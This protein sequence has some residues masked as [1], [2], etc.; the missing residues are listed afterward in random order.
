MET[1]FE[2]KRDLF[3]HVAVARPIAGTLSYSIPA[4]LIDQL[5]V[6]HV[7]LVPL[8][9]RGAET[10]YVVGKTNTVD[11]DVAKVKP[12]HRLIDDQKVF[13]AEQLAFFQ[14]IARYYLVPLGMVIQTAIPSQIRARVL[15]VLRA[16]EA[17]IEALTRQEV[18][19]SNAPILREIISRPDL[20]QKGLTRRLGHD[21]DAAEVKRGVAALIRR[22]W[23]E[24]GEREIGETKGA[25]STVRLKC[26]LNEAMTRVPRA[27]KRMRAI[28]DSLDSAGGAL[29]LPNIIRSHGSS[30]RQSLKRLDAEELLEWGTREK[31][32]AL[33]E[34]PALGPT[35]ALKLNADQQAALDALTRPAVTGCHL[36]YGVTGSGK[37]E[38]FLDAAE[39]TLTQ[40][41]QVL[42]LVPEI[43]LTPQ[44]VGRFRA[45]FGDKVAV[46]HSGLTGGERLGEWRKIRAN[47]AQIA[48]GARS[49]LFAPFSDLGLIVVDEEHDDSYK[50]DDGVPYNAR[51]LAVVLGKLRSCPVVLASA[52]PSMESWYNAQKEH[53]K[54]LHLP[55]RATPRNVP[56]VQLVDLT[57][58]PLEEG[59][60]RPI[61]A[62]EAIDA[63]QE[64]FDAGGKAIVL[65][66]RRGYATLIQCTSCGGTYE[67]PNCGISMT[68]HQRSSRMCCHYC[69]LSLSYTGECPVCRS[70]SLEELGKGTERVVEELEKLFPQI[71]I[72]RMD[73]DSTTIRGAHHRILTDFRSGKTRLLVG[74][75]IVAKGHDFPDV[76]TAVVVSADQGFRLP[77][78]RAG[79]RTFSLLVQMAGRAGRGERAGHV[80]V[81]TWK[82][83]HYVL[84][85]LDHVD[86]FYRRELRLRDA[87]RYP[88]FS[89]LCLVR[90]DGV[91]RR[92]VGDAT[93][94]LARKLR[95][96]AREHEAVAV[97]GPALAALA[98]LVGRWRYQIILRGQQLN[99]FRQF[100]QAVHPLLERSSKKGVRVRWDVDPRSLL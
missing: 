91:N 38:V 40:S 53:Y 78:F 82:P 60:P 13:N 41:K 9:R 24:W 89:R 17:G 56:K 88:P 46:L 72:A 14:W 99:A 94:E 7:V 57:A 59:K 55:K 43:G 54:L 35:E 23:I 80:V 19:E 77:D 98:K 26:P 63:L 22:A 6:G 2:N 3:V 75:Q 97:L 81:Q 84:K 92:V 20:T 68:L 5:D 34:A 16:T 49:A 83:D 93:A 76:H 86:D 61:F 33:L 73:A 79:E 45:R 32:D 1:L 48:V 39:H 85:N 8:G 31:R 52:T 36:L 44:L 70:R 11:F 28:M 90:V 27:G 21:F 29:D 25:I 58:M 62:P 30:A 87:M 42:V 95:Q 65:Y 74:T 50:Q 51:D 67:C 47:V 69:N 100:I 15:Q 37:T 96:V 64:A 10:G 66:N 4:P 12:I 71:P 18:P